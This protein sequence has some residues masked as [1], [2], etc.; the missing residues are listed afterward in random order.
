MDLAEIGEVCNVR[1]GPA[2]ELVNGAFAAV[3]ECDAILTLALHRGE[4]PAVAV[5]GIYLVAGREGFITYCVVALEGS[6]GLPLSRGAAAQDFAPMGAPGAKEAL[7][8]ARFRAMRAM[9]LRPIGQPKMLVC[10]YA[11][12]WASFARSFLLIAFVPI[13]VYI[14]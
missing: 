2:Q 3:V 13:R 4:A 8:P 7:L 12:F 5:F 14:T 1:I 11:R 6:H 10:R 9:R